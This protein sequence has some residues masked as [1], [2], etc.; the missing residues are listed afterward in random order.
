MEGVG[1]GWRFGRHRHFVEL[2]PAGENKEVV[3]SKKG[4]GVVPLMKGVG[5]GWRFGRH[6]HF[7]APPPAGEINLIK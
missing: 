7:V 2:P 5:G 1:G 3:S 6:R 4:Q